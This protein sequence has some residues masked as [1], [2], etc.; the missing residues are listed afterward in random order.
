LMLSISKGSRW[1]TAKVMACCSIIGRNFSCF[2]DSCYH[3]EL[4]S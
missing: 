1:V 4:Y 3:S 2:S